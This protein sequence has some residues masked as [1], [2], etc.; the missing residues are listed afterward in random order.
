MKTDLSTKLVL[1]SKLEDEL[2]IMKIKYKD[3][4]G[5][6]LEAYLKG[7]AGAMEIIKATL[8]GK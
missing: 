7:F 6:H 2:T 1:L 8:R 5:Q 3:V 4:K